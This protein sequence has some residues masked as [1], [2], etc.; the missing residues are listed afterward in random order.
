MSAVT[1]GIA[2]RSEA[3]LGETFRLRTAAGSDYVTQ[4]D[5][6]PATWTGRTIDITEAEA[7]ILGGV[8]TDSWGVA[9][10]IPGDCR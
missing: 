3:T 4:T 6:G 8:T 7:A 5:Y 1:A 10:L 2:L 9:K